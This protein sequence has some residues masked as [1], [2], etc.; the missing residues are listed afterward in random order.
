MIRKQ[1]ELDEENVDW[2]FATYGNASLSWVLNL[3]LL[4]F[5][6]AHTHTPTD[7]AKIGAEALKE[8]L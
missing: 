8:E 2:F 1:I 3:L 6:E 4:K 7:Y 5:R